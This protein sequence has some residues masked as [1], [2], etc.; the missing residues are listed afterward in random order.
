MIFN[1]ELHQNTPEIIISL[2]IL[3]LPLILRNRFSKN[4]LG[5]LAL[6]AGITGTFFGIF[7]GLWEFDT[8]D[9]EGSVPNLLN[10]LKTAFMTSLAGLLA[11][12]IV[13]IFP[14]FYL[15]E[16]TIESDDIGEELVKSMNSMAEE[17]KKISSEI[18]S[19]SKAISSDKDTS[20]VTQ[21]Q[22]IRTTNSDGFEEMKK[23]FNEFAEKVV[24]D[25]TQSLIDALTGVMKDFNAKINEQF[26]EN[27]KELNSAV[28]LMV[29][30]QKENKTQMENLTQ[31]YSSILTG[32]EGIDKTLESS[33]KN[34]SVILEANKELKTLVSDFSTMVDSFSALG[35][36]ASSSLPVIEKNMDSIVKKSD[37]YI[38]QSLSK[39]SSN[40]DEFSKK[41]REIIESYNNN[42]D[43]MIASNADRIK[44]LDEELGNEL[45]KSLE[46][47]G[48]SLATLSSKF[49]NDY[50]P[51]TEKLKKII[52]STNV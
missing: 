41:Q 30:W 16:E 5:G 10:G 17:N 26:G 44:K 14:R 39:V 48:G 24:A 21:L 51:I 29:E 40:Y 6:A 25:N 36:K 46:S 11:N 31:T 15:I 7:L 8:N 32:I 47:L 22:K 9:I 27:F 33:S 42:I 37:D 38:N 28:K 23:S 4:Q 45:T 1:Q 2:F 18:S 13:K 12:L 43:D 3:F 52:D 35:E 20:L 49:A 34:H 19:L 50:G